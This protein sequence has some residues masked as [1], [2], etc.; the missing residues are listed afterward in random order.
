MI[1]RRCMCADCESCS[2]HRFFV[3]F[4]LQGTIDLPLPL[5]TCVEWA[6]GVLSGAGGTSPDEIAMRTQALL[7]ARNCVTLLLNTTM[8]SQ[9]VTA[10]RGSEAYVVMMVVD[11]RFFVLTCAHFV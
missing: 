4:L 1:S 5:H 6:H 7:F 2:S 9:P 11:E 10:A 3:S 8:T